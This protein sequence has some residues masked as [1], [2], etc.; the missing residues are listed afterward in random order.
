[1][2]LGNDVHTIHHAESLRCKASYYWPDRRYHSYMRGIVFRNLDFRPVLNLRTLI[3]SLSEEERVINEEDHSAG[4]EPVTN[5]HI[6]GKRK[7]LEST[8]GPSKRIRPDDGAQ[9]NSNDEPDENGEIDEA[10]IGLEYRQIYPSYWESSSDVINEAYQTENTTFL[11]VYQFAL[12]L[13]YNKVVD[14]SSEHYADDNVAAKWGWLEEEKKLRSLLQVRQKN[15]ALSQDID[16]GRFFMTRYH[17]RLLALSGQLLESPPSS[18]EMTRKHSERWLFLL[19]DIPWP[20]GL[21]EDKLEEQ[22][23]QPLGV[24]RD[25][26]KACAVLQFYNRTKLEASLQLHILPEGTYDPTRDLPFELRTHFTL[27]LAIPETYC[28]FSN[29]LSQTKLNELEGLQCR[30]VCFL[31]KIPL[32]RPVYSNAMEDAVDVTIPFFLNTMHPAPPLAQDVFYELLQ[33]DGLLSTLMPFQRR[34]VAWMLE[35]EGKRITSA[36]TVALLDDSE[37]SSSTESRHLP[38]FWEEIEM[39]GRNFFFNRLTSALSPTFPRP[40][41]VLG[42]ILAEEPGLLLS[43]TLRGREAYVALNAYLGLGKTMECLSLMLLNPAPERNLSNQRWDPE[44]QLHV[45]EIKV[46][47]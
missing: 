43:C 22:N 19:P 41:T 21:A 40:H 30:L 36:G 4:D 25:F 15:M 27:S 38:L 34:T 1:M 6:L 32:T 2:D 37:T 13:R 29:S 7:R 12:H 45:R 26:I 33:P 44:A 28:P 17:G 8:P 35:R 9:G 46:P 39:G 3:S 5:G 47:F 20:D 11:Q 42:G 10:D 23:I 24:H 31:S 18:P 16:M 14:H